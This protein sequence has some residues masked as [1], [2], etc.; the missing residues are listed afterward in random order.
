MSDSP[1]LGGTR[2]ARCR[3]GR[4]RVRGIGQE[5]LTPS[6]DLPAGCSNRTRELQKRLGP[7]RQGKNDP[8]AQKYG[9]GGANPHVDALAKKYGIDK[10]PSVDALAK[11][12]GLTA[13]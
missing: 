6:V 4:R 13:P 9:L 2:R 7:V 10:G 3:S 8:L 1:N 5:R 12:C 11:K